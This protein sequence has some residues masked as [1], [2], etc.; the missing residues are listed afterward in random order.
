MLHHTSAQA[1]VAAIDGLS[2]GL[3]ASEAKQS[4]PPT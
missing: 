4:P 3:I 2:D 1:I